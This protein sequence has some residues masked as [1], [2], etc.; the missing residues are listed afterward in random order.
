[1]RSAPQKIKQAGCL[2]FKAAHHLAY[3]SAE[4]DPMRT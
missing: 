4:V 1:M 2:G 3:D